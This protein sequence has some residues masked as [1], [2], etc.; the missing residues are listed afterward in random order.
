MFEVQYKGGKKALKDYNRALEFYQD[1]LD[2]G[3]IT[4]MI[5]K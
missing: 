3:D 5:I 4:V 1:K 2:E